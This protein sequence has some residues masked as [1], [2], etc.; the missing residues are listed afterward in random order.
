MKGGK[1]LGKYPSNLWEVMQAW[2]RRP[3]PSSP[4]DSVWYGIAEWFGSNDLAKVC[5]HK[6][7]FDQNVMFDAATMF[8]PSGPTYA[9]SKSPTG[10]PFTLLPSDSPTPVPTS[11][12]TVAVTASPTPEPTAAVTASPTPKPTTAVTA[13]P[14]PE[15]T[16]PVTTPLTAEPTEAGTVA[17]DLPTCEQCS[18][19]NACTKDMCTESGGCLNAAIPGCQNGAI[20]VSDIDMCPSSFVCHI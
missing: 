13:S 15:P 7:S 5:R 6:D 8:R 11:V 18:D 19:N 12:P 14:T 2:G 9:P 3:V 4:W 1:I 16:A 10:A 17:S 20:M